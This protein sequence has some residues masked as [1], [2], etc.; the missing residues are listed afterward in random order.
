M[1]YF[2]KTKIVWCGWLQI[3]LTCVENQT[4]VESEWARFYSVW[5]WPSHTHT[6]LHDS[7]WNSERGSQLVVPAWDVL[8]AEAERLQ[9]KV[10]L[11]EPPIGILH[12]FHPLKCSMISLQGEFSTQWVVSERV[13]G[14][15]DCQCHLLRC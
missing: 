11:C 6:P 14:P 13:K 10:P 9:G 4:K 12:P 8:D 3:E 7:S 5:L 1:K 15:L 2:T